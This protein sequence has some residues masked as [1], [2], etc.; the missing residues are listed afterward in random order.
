MKTFYK[1]Q[2]TSILFQIPLKELDKS[3]KKF[4]EST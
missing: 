4:A 1:G 3:F 2:I